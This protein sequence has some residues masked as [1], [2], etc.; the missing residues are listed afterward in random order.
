MRN[1]HIKSIKYSHSREFFKKRFYFLKKILII[2][3]FISIFKIFIIHTINSEPVPTVQKENNHIPALEASFGAWHVLTITQDRGKI[4][5]CISSPIESVGNHLSKRDPYIMVSLFGTNK[6]EVS[7]RAGFLY[8]TNSIVYVSI[9]GKQLRFKA[10]NDFVAWPE[11]QK[12]DKDIAKQMR[13]SKKL[14]A[15]YESFDRTYAVDTYTL[16]GFTKA[17]QYATKLCNKQQ[18]KNL[19]T[20]TGETT[21]DNVPVLQ[22][23]TI[24]GLSY[25]DFEEGL[26]K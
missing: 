19:S 22:N 1:Q 25:Q 2:L 4:C 23:D 26:N 9:D 24:N 20:D 16:E 3:S 18:S 5:Y 7:I 6:L 15:F 21:L 17:Y 14:L 10:E 8:K 12:T 11:K 13:N